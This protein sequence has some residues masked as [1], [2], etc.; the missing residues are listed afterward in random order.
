MNAK[1]PERVEGVT[2]VHVW[3]WGYDAGSDYDY[4]LLDARGHK[5]RKIEGEGV[6]GPVVHGSF[7][8]IESVMTREM[9]TFV[10]FKQPVVC[11]IT[12]KEIAHTT[13]VTIECPAHSH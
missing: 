7:S 11:S 8:N 3:E 2:R 4:E 10:K 6:W 13:V 12:S 5:I 9:Q 1:E